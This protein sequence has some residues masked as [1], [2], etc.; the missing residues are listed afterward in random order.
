L[1]SKYNYQTIIL[2]AEATSALQEHKIEMNIRES[3]PNN[4][5]VSLDGIMLNSEDDIN[6][7]TKNAKEE[8]ATS[9]TTEANDEDFNQEVVKYRKLN[10][11]TV[12]QRI[13]STYDQDVIHR[14]SSALDVLA[15]FIKGHKIIYMES[16]YYTANKLYHLIFPAIFV[17]GLTSILQSPLQCSETGGIILASLSAFVTFMLSIINYMKLDA[18]TESHKITAHQYDKLQTSIEFQ[19]GQVLL[20]SD[21]SL[22]NHAIMQEI[23]REKKDA[24]VF[25]KMNSSSDEKENLDFNRST[26]ERIRS[27][28]KYISK[29]RHEAEQEITKTMKE[30]VKQVEEKIGD[31][32]ETNPFIIPRQ[33]RYRYPLIYNTNVFS[34]IKKIDDYRTKT[35]T[36]LK[37][38]KNEIRYLK[39]LQRANNRHSVIFKYSSF[40][41]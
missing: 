38:V 35:I 23:T 9:E 27:K 4:I 15:S 18:Q 21:P 7:Q 32:K 33:I 16:Q 26:S 34:I 12:H 29:T 13:S 6:K 14:Y 28:I 2:M 25:Y 5:F 40:S 41:R 20:F 17:S 11:N 3:F 1:H 19:S 10:Y 8:S 36:N 24:E 31:I 30:L 22:S 37:N 39:S